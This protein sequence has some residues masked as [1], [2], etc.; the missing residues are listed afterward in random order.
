MWNVMR[1]T[2][3]LP[4]VYTEKYLKKL[5]MYAS[6]E[7]LASYTHFHKLTLVLVKKN[8]SILNKK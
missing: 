5:V 6:Y 3:I 7:D 1:V 4:W 2:G 8:Y